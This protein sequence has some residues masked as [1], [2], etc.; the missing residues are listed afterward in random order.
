MT[1]KGSLTTPEKSHLP[2]FDQ[3][4]LSFCRMSVISKD[5]CVISAAKK[6]EWTWTCLLY[7]E[8]C[9]FY[10]EIWNLSQAA[11]NA[12]P[13]PSL[14]NGNEQSENG[15]SFSAGTNEHCSREPIY[16]K[17]ILSTLH[18]KLT[19]TRC[20][21]TMCMCLWRDGY[22]LQ[23]GRADLSLLVQK[24][25]EPPGVIHQGTNQLPGKTFTIFSLMSHESCLQPKACNYFFFPANI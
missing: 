13:H 15:T 23:Q 9:I 8:R 11:R 17:S 25:L 18:K 12:R 6:C 20:G 24:G 2:K 5:S 10:R 21:L 4:H 1:P 7:L 22:V 14:T 3:C 19:Y 16:I